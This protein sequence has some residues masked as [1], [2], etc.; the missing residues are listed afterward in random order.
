M[1]YCAKCGAKIDDHIKFCLSCGTKVDELKGSKSETSIKKSETKLEEVKNEKANKKKYLSK[2]VL[3]SI[4]GL[5][6]LILL[7]ILFIYPKV[8]S[9]AE[10]PPLTMESASGYWFSTQ[11]HSDEKDLNKSI[12]IDEDFVVTASEEEDSFDGYVVKKHVLDE[13]TGELN[14]T[15]QSFEDEEYVLVMA[16]TED[17]TDT[18][19]EVIL[20]FEN[21]PVEEFLSI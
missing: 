17:S 5:L 21:E 10:Q 20:A 1:A 18:S 12:Y 2:K 14:I 4:V 8:F 11:G 7:F 3:G 13:D 6:T 9:Q 15:V 16:Y 19:K